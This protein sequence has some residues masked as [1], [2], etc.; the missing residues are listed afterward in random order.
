MRRDPASLRV[1]LIGTGR[2]GRDVTRI[3]AE[4]HGVEM[5]AACS[6]NP[7]H[8][9]RDLGELAGLASIGV[10]V[11][12]TP[13]GAVEGRPDVVLI[14]TTSFLADVAPQIA[15]AATA[16]CNVLVTAEEAAYPWDV[17]EGLAA[18]LDTLARDNEVTILGAG[19]NPGFVF[20]ALVVTAAG[21]IPGVQAIDVE[22]RVN[23]RRFS[24][25]V[26]G[27]LGVGYEPDA[28]RSGVEK[29]R[30]FGHIGFPQSMRVVAGALGRRIE[31]IER[32]IEPIFAERDLAADHLSVP[33]GRTAGV[34]Q[35]YTAIVDGEPWYR[36]RLTGHVDPG[37]AG[38]SLRDS[39]SIAGGASIHLELDPGLDPQVTSASVLANSVRRLVQAE[40]GWTTVADL[41]PARPA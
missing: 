13:A 41:P 1:A 27:R 37:A 38:I 4:R 23:F 10:P 33:A 18:E 19:A 39:I 31:R 15:I 30:I 6:R 25:T 12:A 29:G 14:A 34:R 2:V 28:F 9:G 22:R 35:D 26:L 16:G 24:A 7:E 36:A 32:R 11:G 21:A 5:V 20:D 8:Q 40:P 3:L 17:D